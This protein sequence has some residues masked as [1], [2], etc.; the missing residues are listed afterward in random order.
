MLLSVIL[1]PNSY[2]NGNFIG[3]GKAMK[4]HPCF[5][6]LLMIFLMIPSFA[7]A[8]RNIPDPFLSNIQTRATEDVSVMTCPGCD[9][10]S[11]NQAQVFGGE[12]MDATIEVQLLDNTM[13]PVVNFPFED[14]WL[15]GEGL[16][17]CPGGNTADQ[18]TDPNGYTE[19]T[20]SLC[21]GGSSEDYALEGYLWGVAFPQGP[22]PYI[23][24]NSPDVNCD[25]EVNL[26]DLATFAQGFFGTYSYS[27]DFYWDGVMNLHDLA[28]FAQHFG[29]ACP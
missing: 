24:T 8:D 9:G 1:A 10:Y 26:S 2:I 20:H 17:F 18:N 19:F 16:C 22:I 7:L 13:M 6:V 15:E 28:F 29:H 5:L 23:K 3:G 12:F 27:L 11:L 21:G 25:L 4:S 14:I